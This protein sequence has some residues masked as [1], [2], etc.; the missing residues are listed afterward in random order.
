MLTALSPTFAGTQ[1]FEIKR[2]IGEGAVGVVYEAFDRELGTLVALK[3]LRMVSPESLLSL[4]NEFRSVQ[5]VRHPNLVRLGELLEAD[6]TWFFTM[7]LITGRPV[8]D[9]LCPDSSVLARRAANDTNAEGGRGFHEERVRSAI[10]QFARGL[11]ALHAASKVHRDVKPSNALVTREGRVVILDFG[12]ARDALRESFDARRESLDDALVGTVAYMAP[13]QTLQQQVEASADFYSLGVVLYQALTGRLPFVGTFDRIYEQKLA[14]LSAPP[15]AL[16]SGV[17]ADL[18]ALCCDLLAVEPSQ[19]PGAAAIAERLGVEVEASVAV[20]GPSAIVGRERESAALERAFEATRNGAGATVVVVGESGVGKSFLIRKFLEQLTETHQDMLVLSG[21]CYERESVPY[22]AFDGVVDELSQVLVALPEHEVE[23]LLPSNAELLLRAFPVL[24]VVRTA[25]KSSARGADVLNPQELR[26]R[27]FASMRELLKRLAAQRPLVIA[28]DDL[29]WADA[30]SLSLLHEIM[31]PPHEPELLLMATERAGTERGGGLDQR[32]QIPGQVHHVRLGTLSSDAAVELARKLLN[33]AG[34]AATS[35]EQVQRIVEDAKGHPLFIDELVRQR[36][37]GHDDNLVRLDDALWKRIS[38]L[39]APTRRT[40]ELLAVAGSPLRQDTA[41]RAAAIDLAQLFDIALELRADGFLRMNGAGRENEIETYHDRIRESVLGHLSADVR[42]EWHMR[43]G[44]ALEQQ[45]D[46]VDPETLAGHW[47]GAGNQTRAAEYYVRA[48]E[49]AVFA[50]AF[51]RAARLYDTALRTGTF[52]D[53]R[54]RELRERMADALTNAGLLAEAA[55]VRLLLAKNANELTRLELHHT[56]AAQ[57]MCSGHYERGLALLRA[58][59]K[60][61]GIY[62][63]GSRIGV[64]VSALFC[65]FWLLVRGLRLRERKEKAS[66]HEIMRVDATWSASQAYAMSDNIRGVYFQTRCLLMSLAA[67]DPQ[68]VVRSL[69]MSIAHFSAAGMKSRERVKALMATEHELA[70]R[71]GNAEARAYANGAAG[72]A[73]FNA[74]E[75]RPAKEALVHAEALFRDQ[76]VGVAYELNSVR[77]ILFRTLFSLGELRELRARATPITLQAERQNDRYMSIICLTAASSV[78]EAQLDRA[79]A[80][81]EAVKEAEKRLVEGVIH[82]QHY[83]AYTAESQIALY[84]GEA[85]EAYERMAWLMPRLRRALLTRIAPCRMLVCSLRGRAAVSLLYSERGREKELARMAEKDAQALR[86]ELDVWG[87]PSA[88][89]IEG[90]LAAARGQDALAI[91]L[92]G[93]AALGF[94][95]IDMSLYA[96]AARRLEGSLR[97]GDGGAELVAQADRRFAAEG[98]QNP[99]RMT[100]LLAGDIKAP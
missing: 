35:D 17:P 43:L 73:W 97:G 1:R 2:R 71:L 93:Q 11:S 87:Q 86:R 31:R 44:A 49:Q 10:V 55:D 40:L 6:G 66:L 63:P 91:S 90:T 96:A 58:S 83:W 47:S 7:E 46:D 12:V 78:L 30:D 77:G 37:S 25:L 53:E 62:F 16:V 33:E 39:A 94:D 51:E 20:H 50:M 9:W 22:K 61:V 13:E 23:A 59:L 64:I 75:F 70:Q 24:E 74:G 100:A 42:A 26:A 65:R 82:L 76:C 4:K 21:R 38:R 72:I 28:I 48:A 88:H 15:S 3:T 19:R 45:G 98:V 60:T 27:V 54:L 81:R 5:F 8:M 14:G 80:A 34:A 57:L 95:A 18:D 52:S 32:E 56:A 84:R 69:G 79:E 36:A 41:A 99:A 92:L 89:V 67:G 85:R 68:R 29:Q